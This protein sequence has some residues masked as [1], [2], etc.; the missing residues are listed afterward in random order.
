MRTL[1]VLQVDRMTMAGSSLLESTTS[2]EK[3][4][5]GSVAVLASKANKNGNFL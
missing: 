5:K 1:P 3:I 2:G 4:I